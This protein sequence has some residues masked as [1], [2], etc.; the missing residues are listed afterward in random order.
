MHN[1]AKLLLLA[2]KTNAAFAKPQSINNTPYDELLL[3]SF[4]L[5]DEECDL[6]HRNYVCT[7]I[8]KIYDSLS[9]SIY[10]NALLI[11]QGANDCYSY[12]CWFL[13][14]YSCSLFSWVYAFQFNHST[15]CIFSFSQF[16]ETVIVGWTIEF[17]IV[18]IILA[19]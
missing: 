12:R 17:M 14:F 16:Y 1:T 4:Y 8:N 15:V 9:F 19:Q 10:I 5:I 3:D 7:A 2:T 6:L 18:Y 13:Y 11:I